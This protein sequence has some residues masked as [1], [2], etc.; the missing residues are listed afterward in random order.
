MESIC[1]FVRPDHWFLGSRY[2]AAQSHPYFPRK[3]LHKVWIGFFNDDDS[4][5]DMY[6]YLPRDVVDKIIL[7]DYYFVPNTS[8]AWKIIDTKT[9][10]LICKED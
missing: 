7:G 10:K 9:G 1:H 6:A 3:L 2:K 8:G 5:S 4:D